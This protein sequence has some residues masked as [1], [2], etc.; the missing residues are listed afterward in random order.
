MHV[1]YLESALNRLTHGCIMAPQLVNAVV[2]RNAQHF[3]PN[4]DG[5]ALGLRQEAVSIRPNL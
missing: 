5:T 1:D 2:A 3:R 4:V